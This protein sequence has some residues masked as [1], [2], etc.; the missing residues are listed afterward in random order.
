[1]IHNMTECLAFSLGERE[2]FDKSLLI[3][4]IPSCVNV[5][6]TDE[7]TDRAGIDYI[8]TLRGGA[9]INIDAKTRR[10]W[11]S[12]Y[13]HYGE[14]ELALE[15]FSVC[16]EDAPNG[17]GKIGW[18]LSDASNVDMILYTFDPFDS[19]RFYLIPFQH[20][21]MA[22]W[23]N[24]AEWVNKYK[25][26][27]Q[28]SENKEYRRKGWRS[29]AVFVPASIVLNAVTNVMQGAVIYSDY[30]RANVA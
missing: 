13:W 23:C 30:G 27:F 10:K 8:A 2:V 26:K 24:G 29:K 19:N 21:R 28:E 16:P 1:M 5:E 22:F 25:Y 7:V 20:L 6:K 9:K 18:T 15:R 3:K 11:S 12:R 14:P 17:A 4:V